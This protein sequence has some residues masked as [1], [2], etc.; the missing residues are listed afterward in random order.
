MRD[1]PAVALEV[2]NKLRESMGLPQAKAPAGESAP[3]VAKVEEAA[4]GETKEKKTAK[5][6]G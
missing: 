6:K 1:Y 5:P 3:A 4:D 2:E